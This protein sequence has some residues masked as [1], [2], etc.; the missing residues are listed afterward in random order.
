MAT[1]ALAR[2]LRLHHAAA[3]DSAAYAA[4]W[5]ST[6][7]AEADGG[8][9]QALQLVPDGAVFAGEFDDPRGALP[10]QIRARRQ[11]SSSSSSSSSNS[12]PPWHA[13]LSIS[14]LWSL[15]HRKSSFDNKETTAQI[16]LRRSHR[17]IA[18]A[19]APPSAARPNLMIIRRVGNGRVSCD[20]GWDVVASR[21]WGQPV[22]LALTHAGCPAIG[23]QEAAAVDS[24]IGRRVFPRDFP[25]TAACGAHWA[26][27]TQRLI[28]GNQEDKSQHEFPYIFYPE[29][30][31]RPPAKRVNHAICGCLWPFHIPWSAL[32]LCGPSCPL[33]GIPVTCDAAMQALLL[34]TLITCSGVT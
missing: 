32:A 33:A 8:V 23:L 30:A 15:D 14:N 28:A 17:A 29:H 22:F 25:E 31:K 7:M 19:A 16:N 1:Q 13:S 34:C 11:V 18:P 6:S 12:S 26:K 2:A 4:Q 10:Q 24:S 20:D 9:N 21:G 3:N 5:W 27:E